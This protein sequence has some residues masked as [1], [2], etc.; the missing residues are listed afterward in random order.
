MSQT[1]YVQIVQ[2]DIEAMMH[3]FRRREVSRFIGNDLHGAAKRVELYLKNGAMYFY[4]DTVGSARG[5]RNDF[6]DHC[7]Q[8]GIDALSCT[9]IEED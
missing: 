1:N 6:I 3:G 5:R 4:G 8:E 2:T 7:F 9:M